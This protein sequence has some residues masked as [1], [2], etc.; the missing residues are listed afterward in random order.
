MKDSTVIYKAWLSIVA[1]NVINLS[2]ILFT[3]KS[4]LNPSLEALK[5]ESNRIMSIQNR[6]MGMEPMIHDL[7]AI[8]NDNSPKSQLDRIRRKNTIRVA[9]LERK[10][11]WVHDN[12]FYEAEV[13]NGQINNENAKPIDAHSLTQRD[14]NRLLMILDSMKDG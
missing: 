9:I 12:I 3:I 14:L 5:Q 11:Y 4:R 8:F 7:E 2:M 1:I 6:N 10:A 13:V